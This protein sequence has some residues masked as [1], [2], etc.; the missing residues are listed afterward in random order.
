MPKNAPARHA[1]RDFESAVERNETCHR[2]FAAGVLPERGGMAVIT[3]DLDDHAYIAELSALVGEIAQTDK[4]P[5]EW[6]EMGD[7]ARRHFLTDLGK[8]LQRVCAVFPS[9][10]LLQHARHQ[11]HPRVALLLRAFER[12]GDVMGE[13]KYS[14]DVGVPTAA[15]R[16]F[17]STVLLVRF[18]YRSKRFRWVTDNDRRREIKEFQSAC[19]YAASLFQV[20]PMLWVVRVH[21]YVPHADPHTR[22]IATSDWSH[23]EL[24]N[25]A[26]A[27]FGRA[28]RRHRTFADVCGWLAVRSEGFLQGVRF[29]VLVFLD[30]HKPINAAEY[31]AQLGQYWTERCTGFD[32]VGRSLIPHPSPNGGGQVNG[33]GFVAC[34]DAHGL[35]AI[36]GAI[37]AMC[38]QEYQ[39][40]VS[41]RYEHN[42]RRGLIRVPLTP[43]QG[44]AGQS[45]DL[46]AVVRILGGL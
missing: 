29:D 41:K 5:V 8:K 21:L 24:A 18:A 12:W 7:G 38:S 11:F 42:F 36:R 40:R 6:E 32:Q 25:A 10:F 31:A 14:Y 30:G 2:M 22:S 46:S 3:R 23:L 19:A 45:Y 44:W 43:R 26:F 16:A 33:T 15:R 28:L 35:L 34:T 1:E 27:K 9:H 4:M 20:H 13:G 39:L 17:N 37:R